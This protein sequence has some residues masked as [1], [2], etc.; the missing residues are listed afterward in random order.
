[1]KYP[2]VL[3][4]SIALGLSPLRVFPAGPQ[5]TDTPAVIV[6]PNDASRGELSRAIR[7]AF[8]GAPVRLADDALTSSSML[9][10]EHFRPRDPEG[11]PLNGRELS[12]P[13]TFELFKRGSHCLLVRT[14]NGH[15][16][17]LRHTQCAALH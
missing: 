11:R 2:A 16:W 5:P 14:R 4:W 1:M 3:A 15:T 12:R 10:L 7:D 9:S 6:H 17:R 13:E 8:G